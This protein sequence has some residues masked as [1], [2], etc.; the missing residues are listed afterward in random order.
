MTPHTVCIIVPVS[1]ATVVNAA[2]AA[3]VVAAAAESWLRGLWKTGVVV[4]RMTYLPP[5]KALGGG[6]DR[7]VEKRYPPLPLVT[8]EYPSR[9]KANGT[10]R[11]AFGARARA[12]SALQG[13]DRGSI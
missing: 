1:G 9:T 8:R 7:R 6:D 4:G 10:R 13:P 12:R 11:S 2:A 5:L 3:A